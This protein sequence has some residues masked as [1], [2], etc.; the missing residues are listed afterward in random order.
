MKQKIC[1]V[2]LALAASVTMARAEI[3]SGECGANGDNLTWEFSTETSVFT[4]SGTGRMANYNKNAPWKSYGSKI[5]YLVLPEGITYIGNYAFYNCYNITSFTCEALTP[6]SLGNNAISSIDQS[7]PVYVPGSSLAAYKGWNGF[8]NIQAIPGTEVPCEIVVTEDTRYICAGEIY[9]WNGKTCDEARDYIDTLKTINGCDS[10]VILHLEVLPSYTDMHEYATTCFGEVYYWNEMT[11]TQTGIYTTALVSSM[12]C[13][14]VITLHLTVMPRLTG[15]TVVTI[16]KG[17]SFIWHGQEYTAANTPATFAYTSQ[18]APYCDSIVT[19][20]ITETDAPAPCQTESGTCGDNLTWELNCDTLLI[21]SGTGRMTDYSKDAPWHDYADHI[22]NLILP[23]GI[24]HIGKYAFY[25]CGDITSITCE[26]VTPPSASSS[27]FNNINKSIPIYVPGN[28]ISSYQTTS[29]W[30]SFTNILPIPGTEVPF[31]PIHICLYDSVGAKPIDWAI[32]SMDRD[33]A[34]YEEFNY[35]SGQWEYLIDVYRE[36]RNQWALIAHSTPRYNARWWLTPDYDPSDTLFLTAHDTTTVTLVV[37]EHKY[38]LHLRTGSKDQGL[39][40]INSGSSQYETFSS[41]E[42]SDS[43]SIEATP[44]EGYQFSH[45]SDGSTVNPRHLHMTQDF[46]LAAFFECKRYGGDWPSSL[47]DTITI[48]RGESVIISE[49][50]PWQRTIFPT[51]TDFYNDTLRTI[52]GCDSIVTHYIIVTE[53]VIEK[54]SVVFLNYNGE[55]LSEQSVEYGA[56]AKAPEVP[57]REGYTFA[58]WTSDFKHI[59]APTYVIA[60]YDKIGGTVT[61]LSEEGDVIATENVDL[62]LP[63]API[64]AG[65]SFKGWLTESADSKNGIVLR[66]TYTSDKP[67][68]HDDVNITPSSNSAAVIFPFITGALTYELVI[69]DLF[70]HVVCKIMF[71]ATGHLL[72]IAFAPS[73]NRTQQATQTTGFNF[74]VEGLDANTT[75]EYEFV[76]N[77]ETDEVIETLSGSFTTTDEAPTANEQVNSPSAIRKYLEGGHLM[78]DNNNRIYDARGQQV[79]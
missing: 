25:N 6:P 30:K 24:T 23:E 54:F 53:P 8:T 51:E 50:L 49:G 12:G 37:S 2:F 42:Y 16:E 69:R 5:S 41:F 29:G 66:A 75:Y 39:I 14:S 79:R 17:T 11:F 73:R 3:Y 65:K 59:V 78:I 58:D 45:W 20:Y 34:L 22:K 13:D 40:G 19:L 56:S 72:G 55:V 36:A 48:E 63:A 9:N 76:A 74:T 28:S 61:Y 18:V 71:S 38:F 47:M 26:A 4:I 27:A 31:Y 7:C 35:T 1:A 77:D 67:T 32:I 52:R 64:I 60:L 10:I 43:V 46:D 57:A 62:H 68:T 70:G 44:Y 21:I 15:D 33:T